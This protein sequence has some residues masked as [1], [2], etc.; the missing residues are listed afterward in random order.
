MRTWSLSWRVLNSAPQRPHW[1]VQGS[2]AVRFVTMVLMDDDYHD[3]SDNSQG[4]V[5]QEEVFVALAVMLFFSPTAWSSS[6]KPSGGHLGHLMPPKNQTFM[7]F[8]RARLVGERV[9]FGDGG[10]FFLFDLSFSLRDGTVVCPTPLN[11]FL[12]DV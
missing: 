4:T 1:Y 3:D 12:V 5:Q 7:P 10:G 11:N 2:F 9:E 6:P 8:K